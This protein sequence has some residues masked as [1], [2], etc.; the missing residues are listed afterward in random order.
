MKKICKPSNDR[1][2]CQYLA[3]LYVINFL[4]VYPFFSKYSLN[5]SFVPSTGIII[6][7]PPQLSKTK[8]KEKEKKT[9]GHANDLTLITPVCWQ[10]QVRGPNTDSS[11]WF[12]IEKKGKFLP[13]DLC[14]TKSLINIPKQM[15]TTYK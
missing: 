3:F 8:Q 2:V 12:D 4:F 10:S 7:S 13:G 15:Y 9:Y 6:L 1:Y 11:W 14:I 5:F